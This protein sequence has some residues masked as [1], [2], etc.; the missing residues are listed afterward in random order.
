MSFANLSGPL[1][2]GPVRNGVGRNTGLCVL[3]QQY[4]SGTITGATG[5][6][7]RATPFIVPKGAYILDI[8]VDSLQG[9]N[10]GASA[11]VYAG[12]TLDGA[13]LTGLTNLLTNNGFITDVGS[14]INNYSTFSTILGNPNTN[15]AAKRTAA[16]NAD[17]TIYTTI[18]IATG[19]ATQGRV[20]I[21][22]V[23]LQ[24]NEDGSQY[25]ASA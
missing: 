20:N 21:T 8:I 9:M 5:A 22:L 2:V 14:A 24:R 6:K 17:A 13:E 7:I 4:D 18:Q 11:Y 15:A 1:R 12:T 16:L 19:T 10:A 23:Y 25:P 3:A